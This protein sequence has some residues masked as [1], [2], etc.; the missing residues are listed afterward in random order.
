MDLNR[1]INMVINQVI[2]R[3][4]GRGINAGIDG[5]MGKAGK[6]GKSRQRLSDDS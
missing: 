3:V 1:I 4:M 5:L 6:G 2:R